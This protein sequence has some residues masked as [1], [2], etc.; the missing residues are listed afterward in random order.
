MHGIKVEMDEMKTQFQE[1]LEHIKSKE[2]HKEQ[3]QEVD[4]ELDSLLS[5]FSFDSAGDMDP[6][7]KKHQQVKLYT[8][9]VIAPRAPPSFLRPRSLSVL[10]L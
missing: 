2:S 5:W 3:E 10:G 1:I 4:D 8:G 6:L 7:G 9:G